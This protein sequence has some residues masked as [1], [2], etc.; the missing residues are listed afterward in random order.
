[1]RR[2]LGVEFMKTGN[3]NY[4]EKIHLVTKEIQ[5]DKIQQTIINQKNIIATRDKELISLICKVLKTN[6]KKT[7]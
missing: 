6:F 3:S 2:N 5:S 1:M 4:K 7:K